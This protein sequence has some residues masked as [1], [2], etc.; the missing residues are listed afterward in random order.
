MLLRKK[1][2]IFDTRGYNEKEHNSLIQ[3][4]RGEYLKTLTSMVE[5]GFVKD[6]GNLREVLFKI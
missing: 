1:L 3:Q 6:Y 4:K 5:V 2:S